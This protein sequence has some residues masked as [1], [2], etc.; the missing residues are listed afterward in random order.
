MN[1]FTEAERAFVNSVKDKFIK[2][3]SPIIAGSYKTDNRLYTIHRGDIQSSISQELDTQRKDE[4]KELLRLM[5][6]QVR[7]ESSNN[8]NNENE[9]NENED[10][11]NENNEEE[12]EGNNSEVQRR[13]AISSI[14]PSDIEN[15]A[16][17]PEKPIILDNS[18]CDQLYDPCTKALLENMSALDKRMFAIRQMKIKSIDAN[19]Y[20]YEDGKV[21]NMY[22]FIK[23][24]FLN[25][26]ISLDDIIIMRL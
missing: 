25:S 6:K 20:M 13:L 9:N 18:D 22:E 4:F 23:R 21:I 16:G 14:K 10:N 17:V 19:E 7:S 1:D 24:I 8:E 3:T 15:V 12:D 11:E 2:Y 5:D 26:Q